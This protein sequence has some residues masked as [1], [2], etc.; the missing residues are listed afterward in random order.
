MIP[1]NGKFR[2]LIK[3]KAV[4]HADHV[5]GGLVIPQTKNLTR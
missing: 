1:G 2:Q 5:M 3:G 4:K